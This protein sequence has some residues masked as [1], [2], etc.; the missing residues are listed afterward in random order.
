[1]V[2]QLSRLFILLHFSASASPPLPSSFLLSPHP[3]SSSLLLLSSPLFFPS[4]SFSSPQVA[5]GCHYRIATRTPKTILGLPEVMLGLLPGAGGTQRLPKLVRGRRGEWEGEW[6]DRWMGKWKEGR[7]G[8]GEGSEGRQLVNKE[9]CTSSIPPPPQPPPPPHTHT[10][11][12]TP[13][14]L[15]YLMLWTLL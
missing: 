13:V 1:M 14:R 11:T 15:A 7:R 3:S 10:H 9:Y 5:L 8:G 12:H 2:E 4:S 6:R